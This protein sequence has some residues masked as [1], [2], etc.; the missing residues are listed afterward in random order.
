MTEATLPITPRGW[1]M[2][3]QCPNCRGYK[4]FWRFTNYIEPS[5]GEE[6]H[7]PR[8]ELVTLWFL[9]LWPIFVAYILIL[10]ISKVTWRATKGKRYTIPRYYYECKLCGY[11]W[12]ETEG[13]PK[14]PITVRPDLI[15]KGELELKRQQDMLLPPPEGGFD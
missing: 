1:P 11:E 4:S 12:G 9:L 7:E 14:P 2:Q 8:F 10:P 15:L 13:A 5:S 3:V 6:S